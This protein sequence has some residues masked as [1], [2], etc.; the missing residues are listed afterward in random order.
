VLLV[1]L[2]RQGGSASLL[3]KADSGADKDAV[4]V[5]SITVANALRSGR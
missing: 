1:L 5:D 2:L 4:V 3:L